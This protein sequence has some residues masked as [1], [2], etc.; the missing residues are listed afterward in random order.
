MKLLCLLQGC[1]WHCVPNHEPGELECQCCR[2]CGAVRHRRV[3]PL[4]KA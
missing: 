4:M 2:R 1:Q 3:A